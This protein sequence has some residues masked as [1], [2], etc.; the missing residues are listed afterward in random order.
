[1]LFRSVYANPGTHSIST[2]S[3]ASIR[4]RFDQYRKIGATARALFVQAAADQWKVPA[5]EITVSKGVVSHAAS[6][7]TANFAQLAP[8]AAALPLPA[9]VALKAPEQWKLIG[10]PDTPRIEI[11]LKC[12]GK[13]DYGVDVRVPNML[14]AAV[15]HSPVLGGKI[16]RAHV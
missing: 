15:Q 16:G 10:Q 8:A 11:A 6:K 5:S 3:S 1:M 13:A 9:D 14:H 7:R 2:N 12:T 4:N